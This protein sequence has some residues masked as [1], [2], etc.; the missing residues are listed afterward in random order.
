MRDDGSIA[1][2]AALRVLQGL[3]DGQYDVRVGRVTRSCSCP[4][5]VN[6]SWPGE[7]ETPTGP[8]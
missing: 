1:V 8:P 3:Q 6:Q 7:G 4:L 5:S 2:P